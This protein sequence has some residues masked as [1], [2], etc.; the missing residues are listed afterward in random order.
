MLKS[1]VKRFILPFS[2]KKNSEPFSFEIE[3]ATVY[4]LSELERAKGG[5]LIVKQPEEKL[6]FLAQIGYPLW[7]FPSN[8]IAC[9]FDGF[10]NSNYTMTYEELPAAKA[11]IE[12]FDRNSKTIEEYVTFLSDHNSFFHQTKKEKEISLDGLIIDLA[13]KKDLN[14]YRKEATEINQ[15]G[16]L[17][18]LFP[19]FDEKSVTSKIAEIDKMLTS[20]KEEAERLA[21]SLRLINKTTSEYVTELDYAAQ[22]VKDESNAKI[23]AQEE[24]IN[25]KIVKINT[26]YEHRI[27]QAAKSFDTELE[28]LQKTKTKTEKSIKNHEE[29]IKTYSK[30][31][32]AQSQKNHGIYEKRWKEKSSKTK[33]ELNGLKKELKR[34]EKNIKNISKQKNTEISKL[35]FGLEAEIKF[36]RQPLRDLEAARDA[37]MF[38]FKQETEKLLRNERPVIDGLNSAIKLGETI[39][40]KFEVLGTRDQQLKTPALFFVP[41][42]AACY[43]AGSTWR[44]TLY[45][46]SVISSLGVSA[47]LKGVFGISKVKELLT[48]RFK[49]ITALIDKCQV[50]AKQD[51][52]LDNQMREIGEK[53][54]LLR[55]DLV[56]DTMA[57]GLVYL[58]HEGWLSEKE[59]QALNNNLTHNLKN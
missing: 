30:D 38:T 10:N 19:S 48:P 42:Y 12:N 11:F 40:V 43:Q 50:L 22:A 6:V 9:I 34:I 37:K 21:G 23:K 33:K 14:L 16:N 47:K 28:N 35:R 1:E 52:D 53:N 15:P 51:T 2:Q 45:P 25:P 3:L 55:T 44:Y 58:K 57:K 41:F 4:V 20:F 17:A 24:I 26:E 29:K 54:N 18:F 56:R 32:K 39:D 8:E 46:P 59:Y 27:I 5:G 31:A 13:F 7:L 49:A 36:A